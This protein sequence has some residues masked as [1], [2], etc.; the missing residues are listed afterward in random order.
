LVI[1]S[2]IVVLGAAIVDELVTNLVVLEME[3][4][5]VTG[6]MDMTEEFVKDVIVL[7]MKLLLVVRVMNVIDE[8]ETDDCVLMM[9]LELFRNGI[10]LEVEIGP[11]D[12]VS[13]EGRVPEVGIETRDE[14]VTG[15]TT[16]DVRR[17]VGVIETTEE[18]EIG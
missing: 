3:L 1:G 9:K 5:L 8:F 16:L 14:L 6:V 4:L 12:E 10:V 11:R 7:G 15:S 17:E 13:R 18:F 2:T